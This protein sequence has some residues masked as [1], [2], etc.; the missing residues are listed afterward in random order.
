MEPFCLR[1][2]PIVATLDEAIERGADRLLIGVA[3]TGGK[4]D[5]AWRPSLLEAID[6]G[7]HL[8]A[9]LHTQLADDP[10]LREAA[11][12]TARRLRDL[13]AAPPDLTVPEGPYSRPGLAC[14]WSTAS[15]RTR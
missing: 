9:G 2:V 12:G 15:A 8:E 5:P 6:A 3:P 1:P 4:L 14:G 11:A 10:E 13:R 7:L